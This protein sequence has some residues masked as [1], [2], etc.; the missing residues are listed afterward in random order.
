MPD[1][2]NFDSSLKDAIVSKLVDSAVSTFQNFFKNH[3]KNKS[4]NASSYDFEEKILKQFNE[5]YNWSKE[6]EFIGL[7]KPITT[8]KTIQLDY[9]FSKRRNTDLDD[10]KRFS[11]EDIITSLENVIIEGDLGSGKST[12]LKRIL[13]DYYF[14][15]SPKSC[16]FQ[17]P[18]LIRFRALTNS[19]TLYTYICNLLGINYRI[20]IEKYEVEVWKIKVV[21]VQGKERH[22][23]YKDKEIKEELKYFIGNTP[24][25]VA[26][27][28]LFDNNKVVL[29]MDGLDEVRPEILEE[30]QKDLKNLSLKVGNS[31]LILTTRLN[32]IKAQFYNTHIYQVNELNQ[33]QIVSISSSWLITPGP[34][35]KELKTKSYS[36]L[37]NRPLFLSF[38]I[39]L[40]KENQKTEYKEE[41]GL[42]RYSRDVYKRIIELLITKWD[43]DRDI[44][45]QSKYSYFDKNK[46]LEFLSHLSFNLTY[47]IKQ[48]I[49]SHDDL[50]KAYL[51]IFEQFELPESEAEQVAE[52]LESH[53][54]IILR[55][56][57][58]KFEF[59]HLAIQEFLCAYYIVNAPFNDKIN[60][61]IKEYPAPLALA[62]SLSTDPVLWFYEL[63]LKLNFTIHNLIERT[64]VTTQILNRI[65]IETPYFSTN[66]KLGIA[67]MNLCKF[68]NCND[69]EFVS[70]LNKFLISNRNIKT[71]I[72]TVL[73]NYSSSPTKNES[74]NK[75]TYRRI[76]HQLDSIYPET[77]CLPLN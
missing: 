63:S 8:E 73:K 50:K 40:Y 34:F 27:C 69:K 68:S 43:E 39:L 18:I 55:S 25:D 4:A 13:S 28:E 38:L 44:Y 65:I 66:P 12:T 74:S 20:E 48:K 61:Y 49:F 37:A 29:I 36:E 14:S 5:L 45:R 16:P 33:E 11:E 26:L 72:E 32:Y 71:S 17:Y 77:L 46:K 60:E 1:N 3:G 41:Q 52:E 22:E 62:V 76:F 64:Q 21:T 56:S 51:K 9:Y 7:G 24:I 15:T 6:I 47:I 19:G 59:S 31:K 58:D 42:P 35:L 67:I 2:F 53:V 10:K 75:L 54:G 70:T 57:F 23:K 30:I